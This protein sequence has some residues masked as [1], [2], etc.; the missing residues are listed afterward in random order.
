MELCQCRVLNLFK[1]VRK[2]RAEAAKIQPEVHES[3]FGSFTTRSSEGTRLSIW[4]HNA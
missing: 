4:L 2:N 1:T 3:V